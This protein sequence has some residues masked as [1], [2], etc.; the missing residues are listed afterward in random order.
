MELKLTLENKTI[1]GQV[2]ELDGISHFVFQNKGLYR[3]H[4]GGNS[5]KA[6]C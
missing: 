3:I 6:D 4:R 1:M 2:I 5:S